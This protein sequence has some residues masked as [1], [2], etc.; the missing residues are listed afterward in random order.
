MCLQFVFLLITRLAAWLRLSRRE[1]AWKTAEIL[2]LR[3]QLAVLQRRQR[4]PKLNWADRALLA[5]LLSV[6]P[7]ARRQGMRLLVTPDTIVRWHRDIIR[8]RWAS[9]S[10]RGRTGR[11]ATRRTIQALV[12]QL[13]RENPEWGYRRIHGE[14]A[15]L[16]VKIAASTV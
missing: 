9:R 5:A 16:G 11:P 15:G 4:R 1:E 13:A 12:L 10:T 2:I 3:H 7:K 6:I 8:R 14:L